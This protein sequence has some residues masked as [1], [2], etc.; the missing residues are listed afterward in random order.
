MAESTE[1]WEVDAATLRALAARCL[2]NGDVEGA[3][4]LHELAIHFEAQAKRP[5]PKTAAPVR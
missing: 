3:S 4:M 5:D 1:R 2:A